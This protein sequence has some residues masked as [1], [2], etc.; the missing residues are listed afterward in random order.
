M[1]LV[2]ANVLIEAKNRYYAFDIAPGFWEWLDRA[3]AETLACSID[4]VRRELLEG[5]DELAHWARAHNGFFRPIDQATTRHFSDLSSWA[6]SRGFT[7]AALAAFT[8]NNADYLLVAYA[9][10]HGHVVVT[11]ERSQPNARSRVL[12]P[13]ACT[14][15][16]VT[17][18]DTFQMLRQSGAYLDLRELR[19]D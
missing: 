18:T 3:H 4:A 11:H 7:P 16:G 14:A 1:Y 9:R 13:D 6:T 19:G 5:D 2:D 15:M 17:T 8:G 12:I 10:E